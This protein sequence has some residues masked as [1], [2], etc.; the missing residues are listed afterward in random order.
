LAYSTDGGSTWTDYGMSMNG[1]TVLHSD[2]HQLA[3]SATNA[4]EVLAG[5]DGGL[6]QLNFAWSGSTPTVTQKSLNPG[7]GITQLYGIA[8]HPTNANDLL[9]GAQDN[10]APSALGSLSTWANPGAGDGGFCGWD[11]PYSYFFTTFDEGGVLTYDLNGNPLG[12]PS[13]GFSNDPNVAFI[14]PTVLS[15]SGKFLFF[16]TNVLQTI[17]GTNPE[18]NTFRSGNT[19]LSNNYYVNAIATAPSNDAVIYT[20]SA[21]GEIWYSS[22]T[23]NA[24]TEIDK[25][26]LPGSNYSVGAISVSPANPNDILVGYQNTG[27]IH[28]W[29][30]SATNGAATWVSV[31]GTGTSGLPDIPIN[32][33][34]R[35]YSNPTTTWYVG[36]DNGVFMTT[37]SGSSWA[38]VDDN[39]PA[40]QVFDLKTVGTNLFVGTFGRG[41][42]EIPLN[43]TSDGVSGLSVA[44]TFASPNTLPVG[45]ITL[46]AAA[47]TGGQAYTLKSSSTAVAQVPASGTVAAGATSGTFSVTNGYVS[48]ATTITLTATVGTTSKTL[49]YKVSPPIPE[50]IYA[51]ATSLNGGA[52]DLCGLQLNGDVPSSG[53]TAALKSSNTAIATVPATMAFPGSARRANFTITTKAVAT[54][55]T[56]TITATYDG[57]STSVTITVKSSVS[58]TALSVPYAFSSPATTPVGTVTLSTAAPSGGQTYTVTSSNTNVAQIPTPAAIAAGKTTGTFEVINQYVSTPTTITLT[59]TVDGNGK[60]VSYTVSPP[61]PAYIYATVTS[62]VGGQAILCGMQLTANAPTG[63][64]VISLKSSNLAVATV[65]ATMTIGAGARRAN[66]DI[67]TK[68]V[69]KATAVT[70]TATYDG[71]STTVTITVNP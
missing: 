46:S 25:S 8:P 27:I 31:S 33:I 35:D 17:D 19:A 68:A 47:P 56:V 48:T 42:W 36:T 37:N 54:T 3:V 45:T 50:Y 10:A 16:A 63:G 21:D 52:S 18:A 60:A 1:S 41:V 66:F 24:F 29:R 67:T 9:S 7:L 43:V 5:C 22:T 61:V 38:N 13:N 64:A 20:G 26:N 28:L 6:F 58:F 62:I 30:C 71:G 65:P 39:L 32:A 11:I 53:A 44:A 23:G 15:E 59:A 40:V 70:I 4:N 55:S 51:T 69:T 2:Q 14:A 57:G 12:N 49:S 34:A